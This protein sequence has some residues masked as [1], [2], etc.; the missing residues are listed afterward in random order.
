MTQQRTISIPNVASDEACSRKPKC[1]G[2]I[3]VVGSG[4]W[5][6]ALAVLLA[7]NGYTVKMW[8]VSQEITHLLQ[9]QHS[10][11]L[12]EIELSPAIKPCL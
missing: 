4:S 8:G 2:D 11:Y 6:T 10:I 12:P 9:T 1:E 7:R 5:G 3:A